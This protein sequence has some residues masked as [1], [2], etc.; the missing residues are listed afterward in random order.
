[1]AETNIML[2]LLLIKRG[3]IGDLLLA[4]P[5][6]RELKQKIPCQLDIV[7]GKAASQVIL[8]NP[9]VDEKFI[10]PDEDFGLSGV[11]RLGRFMLS[12]RG[13]YDYVFILDKHWY[14]NLLARI[15]G[16]RLVG[17][18]R[19]K[20]SQFLLNFYVPYDTV[21]RY[22]GLYYLDLL[23][24][25]G[26]A[27]VDYK[28]LGL[29]LAITDHDK[30]PIDTWIKDNELSQFVVVVNSG[31]N[32][33]YEREGLR[34]LPE[35]KILQLLQSLLDKKITVILGGGK[36]DFANNEKY[37]KQLESNPLLINIAGKFSLSSFAYLL[38]KADH[39]YTTDCGAMH[40][41]VVLGLGE[42]LTAFFGPTNPRHI[43]PESY[44]TKSAVWSDEAIYN[45][46]Y[47]LDGSKRAKEP[48]Y[49]Q[50]LDIIN[51][52]QT[53]PLLSVIMP[54]YNAEK[55]L[56]AAIESILKQNY[57]KFEFLIVDDGS[58]DNSP[59][60][61]KKYAL[62]DPRIKSF[63]NERN[64][65]LPATL[66]YMINKASGKYIARMDA[67]D[68]AEPCRLLTQINYLEQHPEIAV[69]GSW[70]RVYDDRMK[71][72]QYTDRKPTSPQLINIYL[73]L[74]GSPLGH[75][76]VMLRKSVFEVVAG[77]NQSMHESAEDY[78]LW[79]R[80]S[81]HG[82]K[83]ANIPEV[84]LNYRLAA[85]S[86]SQA[87]KVQISSFGREVIRNSLLQLGIT[88]PNDVEHYMQWFILPNSTWQK[89]RYILA[90]IILLRRLRKANQKLKIYPIAEFDQFLAIFSLW[91]K[92]KKRLLLWG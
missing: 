56:V 64:L 2:K 68:I 86:V 45:P 31:G 80:L 39:F 75:P 76:T 23:Q 18:R 51:I 84:L 5:L 53:P 29:D 3:A 61:I 52:M 92:F 34:M 48:H 43:L 40:L 70:Y 58:T 49:F 59:M 27:T 4:T 36:L 71:Q 26:L 6:I 67:D 22:H 35:S 9:Y 60:I 46:R 25:S 66:N 91:H 7:V 79:L 72:L 47:Q 32:N 42:R 82:F 19:E 33:A 30:L 10:L 55:Y 28:D 15:L 57:T 62:Q 1:M 12:L 41:G 54:V 74:W 65:R 73:H 20:F 89:I 77:Y 37:I 21:L 13:K 24:I 88:N 50:N 87:N 83:F 16:S 81:N 90:R 63:F 44:L 78:D 11:M 14:F 38:D 85:T 8:Q 17:Y 69:V